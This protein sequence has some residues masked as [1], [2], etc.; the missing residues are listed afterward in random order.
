MPVVLYIH[1]SIGCQFIFLYLP[2][3]C[4]SVCLSVHPHVRLFIFMKGH[5]LSVCLMVCQCIYLS[6]PSVCAPVDFLSGHPSIRLPIHL[7]AKT[8]FVCQFI[9]LSLYPSV[10]SSVNFSFSSLICLTVCL[11]IVASK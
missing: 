10:R 7:Y 6:L 5:H 3:V 1:L 4:P 11:F 9:G 8:P 2:N